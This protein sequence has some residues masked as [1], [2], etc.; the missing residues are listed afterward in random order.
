MKISLP[1]NLLETALTNCQNFLYKTD[2]SQITSHIC[3]EAKDDKLIL[4]ATDYEIWLESHINIQPEAQGNAT[5]N[6]KQI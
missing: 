1:K 3:F 5:A 6:G 2:R 4:K